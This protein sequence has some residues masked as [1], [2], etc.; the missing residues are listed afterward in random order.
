MEWNGMK[1]NRMEERWYCKSRTDTTHTSLH[2]LSMQG[3]KE[4]SHNQSITQ[5]NT[6]YYMYYIYI[7]RTNQSPNHTT[8]TTTTCTTCTIYIFYYMYYIYILLHVLYIYILRTR[9]NISSRWSCSC[10]IC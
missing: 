9:A 1:R 4:Q 8:P 7:L 10:G 6:Y 2:H 5:S 3:R